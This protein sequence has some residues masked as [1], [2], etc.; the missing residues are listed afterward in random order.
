MAAEKILNGEPMDLPTFELLCKIHD[1]N[2]KIV[3]P[4]YIL[5]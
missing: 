1:L 2:V 4:N 5:T 3:G